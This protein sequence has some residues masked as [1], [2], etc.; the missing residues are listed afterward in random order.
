M[1]KWIRWTWSGEYLTLFA[2]LLSVLFYTLS[3]SVL[4]ISVRCLTTSVV[5]FRLLSTNCPRQLS[6]KSLL[7]LHYTVLHANIKMCL[8]ESNDDRRLT[9]ATFHI[10]PSQT[11]ALS[12]YVTTNER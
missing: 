12:N 5:S 8:G 2:R 1:W 6:Y 10:R 3:A 4:Y 9:L 7:Q 11:L